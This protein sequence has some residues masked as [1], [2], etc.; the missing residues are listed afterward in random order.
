MLELIRDPQELWSDYGISRLKNRMVI[1][2]IVVIVWYSCT[3]L[4]NADRKLKAFRPFHYVHYFLSRS[5]G[6]EEVNHFLV[7]V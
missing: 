6:V 7:Q 2:V 5:L 1:V 4:L 3:L